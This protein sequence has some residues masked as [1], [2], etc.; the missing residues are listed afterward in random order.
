MEFSD[1]ESQIVGV[2]SEPTIVLSNNVPT[3]TVTL[4]FIGSGVTFSPPSVTLG[5][6]ADT[7]VFKFTPNVI[8]DQFIGVVLSGPGAI[9][10]E[11]QYYYFEIQTF[12]STLIYIFSIHK[13]L[14]III[15]H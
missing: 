15:F 1:T 10:F 13:F 2:E 6:T 11:Q 5:P 7:A 9:L 8:G 12:P 4:T 3:D 14:T